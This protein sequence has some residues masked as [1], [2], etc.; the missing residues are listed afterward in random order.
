MLLGY[1]LGRMANL[2]A[3]RALALL[4]PDFLAFLSKAWLRTYTASRLCGSVVCTI[5]LL[6]GK[7]SSW[8]IISEATLFLKPLTNV[9]DR[10]KTCYL[11]A[12]G[13]KLSLKYHRY[14]LALAPLRTVSLLNWDSAFSC[15][16]VILLGPLI[17]NIWCKKVKKNFN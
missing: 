16:E 14:H 17:I 3:L 7:F 13:D 8:S 9:L 12:S 5:L 2:I 1:S 10:S 11:C 6:L 4:T 15:P